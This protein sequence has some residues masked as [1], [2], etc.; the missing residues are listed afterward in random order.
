MKQQAVTISVLIFTFLVI[1]SGGILAAKKSKSSTTAANPTVTPLLGLQ[2][3]T[4][5]LDTIET[6]NNQPRGKEPPPGANE[7]EAS[8]SAST[9][10][11]KRVLITLTNGKSFEIALYEDL[12]PVAVNNFLKK[13]KANFYTGLLFFRVEKDPQS[14]EIAVLQTGDPTNTG[15]GGSVMQAE[16]NKKPF[17][18]GSIG[19][20][21]GN[22]RDLNSDSQFFIVGKD[23]PSLNEEYTNFGDVSAGFDVVLSIRQGQ[24]IKSITVIP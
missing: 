2:T 18:A 24:P 6:A 9:A 1:I 21:R 11:A 19:V 16:Y 7:I 10:S 17:T 20:A 12:A 5:A 15:Q 13:A 4:P 14:G 8:Q 23:M 22:N 3:F